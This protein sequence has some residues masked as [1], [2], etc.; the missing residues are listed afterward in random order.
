L[1]QPRPAPLRAVPALSL[2]AAALASAA[3]TACSPKE[4]ILPGPR[5]DVRQ[6][7]EAEATY[8]KMAEAGTVV[9]TPPA[10]P[11]TRTPPL[12]K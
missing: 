2:L 11:P 5:F 1:T 3:L 8:A 6:T 4:V 12:T 9:T 7:D 10:P